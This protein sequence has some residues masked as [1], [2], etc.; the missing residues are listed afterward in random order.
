VPSPTPSPTPTPTPVTCT[1]FCWQQFSD[2]SSSGFCTGIPFRTGTFCCGQCLTPGEVFGITSDALTFPTD[3]MGS[4]FVDCDTRHLTGYF[5]TDC[6]STITGSADNSLAL[7]FQLGTCFPLDGEKWRLIECSSLPSDVCFREYGGRNCDQQIFQQSVN[8]SGCTVITPIIYPPFSASINNGTITTY[9]DSNCT[10]LTGAPGYDFCFNFRQT[11]SQG[12]SGKFTLGPCT[13]GDPIAETICLDQFVVWLSTTT[14]TRSQITADPH[15]NPSQSIGKKAFQQGVCTQVAPNIWVLV[16]YNPTSTGIGNV[17]VSVHPDS[18][19]TSGTTAAPEG[20]YFTCGEI[21]FHFSSLNLSL[22]AYEFE[23]LPIDECQTCTEYCLSSW[24][25]NNE[26]WGGS[27]IDNNCSGFATANTTYCCDHCY[28]LCN[29]LN[30]SCLGVAGELGIRTGCESHET[31][32]YE[33]L[34]CVRPFPGSSSITSSV[35]G[36]VGHCQAIGS[37]TSFESNYGACAA[38]SP[39]CIQTWSPNNYPG[40]PASLPSSLDGTCSGVAGGNKQFCCNV[41]YDACQLFNDTNLGC[42]VFG[43]HSWSTTFT[44]FTFRLDCQ[45]QIGQLYFGQ[46][47]LHAV[48]SGLYPEFANTS[49]GECANFFDAASWSITAGVCPSPYCLD[50][51]APLDFPTTSVPTTPRDGNCEGVPKETLTVYCGRCYDACILF[52]VECSFFSSVHGGVSFQIDCVTGENSLFEGHTCS[53]A[54]TATTSSSTTFTLT[55]NTLGTC[56]DYFNLASWILNTGLCPIPQLSGYCSTVCEGESSDICSNCPYESRPIPCGVCT[57]YPDGDLSVLASC[58]STD[59]TLYAGEFCNS[60]FEHSTLPSFDLPIC[61]NEGSK[62]INIGAC[63]PP[64]CALTPGYWKIRPAIYQTIVNQS[65]FICYSPGYPLINPP[66]IMS[67]P[68]NGSLWLMLADPYYAILA[69]IQSNI[70]NHCCNDEMCPMDSYLGSPTVRNCFLFAQSALATAF[71]APTPCSTCPGGIQLPPCDPFPPLFD[72][73]VDLTRVSQCTFILDAFVNGGRSEIIHCNE[74]ICQ[75]DQDG[76]GISNDI[77]NCPLVCNE[78]QIDTDVDGYGDA[79]DFCPEVPSI[80]N[81]DTD[82]DG[83][84]DACDN[85]PF[86]ANPDQTDVDGDGV[87]DACDNC[88]FVFNPDQADC[89]HDGIGNACDIP[90]CGNGCIESFDN[91]TEDCDSG[92]YNCRFNCEPGL[93]NTT[94]QIVPEPTTTV[95]EGPLEIVTTPALASSSSLSPASPG[96]QAGWTI[97]LIGAALA[98]VVLSV[99]V[100]ICLDR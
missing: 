59:V 49:L 5:G 50:V 84:G 4:F 48:P 88:E 90:V 41:C 22:A 37:V 51:W 55:D 53:T 57:N 100:A 58:N 6:L 38:C 75:D 40:F 85:C 10:I 16:I 76:D 23:W 28:R 25:P 31:R 33:D 56:V 63:P 27:I 13:G 83:L 97:L 74:T 62:F 1:D 96:N 54:F 94:C 29:L 68:T 12:G 46:S 71:P 35:M 8:F 95:A 34:N 98:A 45:T 9:L 24:T 19:C 42:E 17:L 18:T 93:C 11:F 21:L 43:R 78:D 64:C 3:A 99:V 66:V 79:C 72:N 15:C 73:S 47:C 81:L 14:E 44:G 70:T 82:H 30:S 7:N 91:I 2:S 86:V 69:D 92:A 65:Q 20:Q 26:I 39:Y 67:I 77:D 60:L 36:P 89:D 61:L 87:G 52:N 80:F 32:W